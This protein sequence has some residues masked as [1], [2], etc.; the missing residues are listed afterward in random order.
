MALA[1]GG[2]QS[3]EGGLGWRRKKRSKVVRQVGKIMIIGGWCG[4]LGFLQD[5]PCG[6]EAPHSA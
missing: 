5:T 6:H 2:S 1:S 4:D 3:G